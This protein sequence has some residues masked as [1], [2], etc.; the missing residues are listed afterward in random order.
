MSP[1]AFSCVCTCK[2][3]NYPYCLFTGVLFFFRCIPPSSPHSSSIPLLF[4]PLI[5]RS[6]RWKYSATPCVKH[7]TPWCVSDLLY[8]CIRPLL[9][10]YWASFAI[11]LGLFD[12]TNA[13]PSFWALIPDVIV[14]AA[15]FIISYDIHLHV[16]LLLM[17][18]ASFTIVLSLIYLSYH[19]ISI[20]MCVCACSCYVPSDTHT[21][22]HTRVSH[23]RTH[24]SACARTHTRTNEIEYFLDRMCALCAATFLLHYVRNGIYSW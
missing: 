8:Y 10:L 4:S 12:Y 3:A 9:L 19:M 23:A 1:Y 6:F 15:L 14:V 13:F 21:H 24:A 22:M 2:T 20:H 7:P 17:Y 5:M 11:V 16:P 18:W